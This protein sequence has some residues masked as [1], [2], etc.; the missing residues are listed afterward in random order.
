MEPEEAE[1]KDPEEQKRETEA[2][3]AAAY[4]KGQVTRKPTAPFFEWCSVSTIIPFEA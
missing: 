4:A 3:I 2:A 1:D